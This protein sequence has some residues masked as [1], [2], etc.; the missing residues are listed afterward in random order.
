MNAVPLRELDQEDYLARINC[1]YSEH[2][3]E[4][5]VPRMHDVNVRYQS[6]RESWIQAL[7]LAGMGC[8]IMPEFLPMLPNIAT[9]ILI[10]PQIH[11]DVQLVTISGR[12][13]SPPIEAFINLA[14]RYDWANTA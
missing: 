5:G 1:E 9:R 3:D 8:A 4:L 2:F 11:R 7:I 10:E 6:E 12:R 13:Y 14:Q